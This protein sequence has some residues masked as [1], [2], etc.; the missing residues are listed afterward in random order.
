MLWK[1]P[2]NGFQFYQEKKNVFVQDSSIQVATEILLNRNRFICRTWDNFVAFDG[3]FS[4]T[5]TI[6][7]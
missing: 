1:I 3:Q 4:S 2:G 6:H 7:C 5:P